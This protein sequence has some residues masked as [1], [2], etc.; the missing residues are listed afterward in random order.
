M[1]FAVVDD[2]SSDPSDVCLFSTQAVVL[3]R[4]RSRT[5]SSRRGAGGS[6]VL[7]MI[8][9][10]MMLTF[11]HHTREINMMRGALTSLSMSD[12]VLT[13]AFVVH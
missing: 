9:D 13:P 5:T 8:G 6:D 1:A 4:M 12:N 11:F 3:E 10:N 2:V 7:N